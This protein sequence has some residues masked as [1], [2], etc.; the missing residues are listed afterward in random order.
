MP[1]HSPA[2]ASTNLEALSWSEPVSLSDP[3]TAEI[4]EVAVECEKIAELRRIALDIESP[5]S[6]TYTTT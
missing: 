4:E 2:D 5:R 1:K 3:A 6:I